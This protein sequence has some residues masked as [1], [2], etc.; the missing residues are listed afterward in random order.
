MIKEL[1]KRKVDFQ[2][3]WVGT[4]E[5][6]QEIRKS[7]QC[8]LARK[9]VIMTGPRTDVN[10]LLQA[11]DI[12]IFP[13]VF[14]G[15][16]IAAVEAQAADLPTLCS[17]TIPKEVNITKRCQFLSIDDI[18]IWV[19]ALQKLITNQIYKS[20]TIQYENIKR[21]GYDIIDMAKWLSEFYLIHW[22]V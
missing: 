3:L 2:F 1:K 10:E 17:N 11:M 5:K 7:L 6:E 18:T 16:G 22:K 21:A 20:R 14:E 8:E 12:F 4:G 15:L 9:M 19:N 13:S